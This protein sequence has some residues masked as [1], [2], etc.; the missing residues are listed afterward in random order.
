MQ[1]RGRRTVPPVAVFRPADRPTNGQC[2]SFRLPGPGCGRYALAGR[3][4]IPAASPPNRPRSMS[5]SPPEPSDREPQDRSALVVAWL[6]ALAPTGFLSL[7]RAEFEQTM[8]GHVAAMADALATEPLSVAAGQ[9]AGATLVG[10]GYTDAE[11]LRASVCVLAGGLLG[12]A[13]RSGGSDPAV[14]AFA[15]LGAVTAG[16][17]AALRDW[18]FDQQEEV[19]QALQRATGAAERRSRRNEAWFR[20]VFVRA[21]IG[22][23]ISDPDGRLTLVNPALADILGCPPEELVGRSLDEFFHTQETDDI[24]ADYHDLGGIGSRP[25]RRRRQLIRTDGQLVWCYLAVSVLRTSDSDADDVPTLHLTMVENVSDLHLL[26]D[27]TS[28]QTLHDVLTGLPNRQYLFSQLQSQLAQPTADRHITLYHLDLDGFAAI[29][30]GLGPE[31]GDRLL[32]VV[33]RRLEN[34]LAGPHALIARL[35]GDE[36]AVLCTPGGEPAAVL[37]MIAQINEILAEPVHLPG[38]GVGLSASIGVAHGTP[39]EIEPFELLRRAEI[40]LRRAQATGNRQWAAYDRHRDVVDRRRA[41]LAST[42]SG[43]L[44]F[45]ELT[46]QWQ[47]WYSLA[48]GGLIGVSIRAAWDHPEYGRV[49]HPECLALAELTGAAVPLAAWLIDASCEQAR[50]WR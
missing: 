34:Q 39:G 43:A 49:G 6:K 25:L 10:A 20:E 47:P 50:Q 45:G 18:L 46:V 24:R 29:N 30:H 37:A 40:S 14:R 38:G 16:Y 15:M 3:P 1:S 48:D 41:T 33:A 22:I 4:Q 2:D 11:S 12:L 42:L 13:G 5:T 9:R 35:T 17:T 23:A 26:Q 32:L 19:K 7:P 8:A 31:Y 28:Y 27:L 21:A 36:F 44:E